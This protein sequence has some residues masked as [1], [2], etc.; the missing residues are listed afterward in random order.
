[1]ERD[2]ISRFLESDAVSA[3]ERI[4]HC[5]ECS[6]LMTPVPYGWWMCRDHPW[7]MAPDR[8]HPDYHELTG[9]YGR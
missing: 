1:M 3:K 2:D 5:P 9:S 6:K 7:R 8:N 4:P